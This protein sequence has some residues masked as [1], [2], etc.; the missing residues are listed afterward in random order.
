MLPKLEPLFIP[1][2]KESISTESEALKPIYD[3]PALTLPPTCDHEDNHYCHY[4]I[5]ILLLLQS[6]LCYYYY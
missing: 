1:L 6:L 4:I 5:F 3:P 2:L